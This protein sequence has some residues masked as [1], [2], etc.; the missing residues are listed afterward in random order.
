MSRAVDG[1]KRNPLPELAVDQVADAVNRVIHGH[2]S[3]L[4]AAKVV[5]AVACRADAWTQRNSGQRA[6]LDLISFPGKQGL[7]PYLQLAIGWAI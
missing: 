4:H 7:N 2:G 1:V 3:I 6:F 5:V